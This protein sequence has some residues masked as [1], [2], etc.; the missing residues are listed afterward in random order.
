M[1]NWLDPAETFR[2]IL[3]ARSPEHAASADTITSLD[4]FYSDADHNSGLWKAAWTAMQELLR[5]VED[6]RIELRG[7]LDSR[8]PPILIDEIDARIGVLNPFG[9][10]DGLGGEL[11]VGSLAEPDRI[12]IWRRVFCSTKNLGSLISGELQVDTP[13]LPALLSQA[14]EAKI[15]VTIR[16]IYAEEEERQAKPPNIK[17]LTKIVLSRLLK[18]GL[19][20]SEAR[21][22]TIGNEEEFKRLRWPQGKKAHSSRKRG[23]RGSSRQ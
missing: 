23:P 20:T 6:G 16:A 17:E 11:T 3:R 22:A 7:E 5:Y 21:I 4:W 1:A 10:N 19:R 8:N 9:K 18:T 13:E 2:K 12:R 14:S 15:R